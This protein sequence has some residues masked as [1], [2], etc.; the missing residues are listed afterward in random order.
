ML[1]STPAS[2][3]TALNA[4]PLG[5]IAQVTNAQNHNNVKN[6]LVMF[7][8]ERE[9]IERFERSPSRNGLQLV[10]FSKLK[11]NTRTNGVSVVISGWKLNEFH[12]AYTLRLKFQEYIKFCYLCEFNYY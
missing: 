10:G 7:S 2:P 12:N 5:H 3:I 11:N 6:G 9:H 8:E 1:Q 4:A